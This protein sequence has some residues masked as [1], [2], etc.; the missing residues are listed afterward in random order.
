MNSKLERQLAEL[1][2]ADII[3]SETAQK[4]TAFYHTKDESKPNRLFTIFGVLGALLSGL[5][6]ILIIAHNWDDMPRNI[7]TIFAFIP[8]LIGQIACGYSLIKK[9]SATWIESSATFLILAV[10]ATISLVSQIYNIPGDLSNFLLVWTIITA[11]LIY[12]LRSNLAVIIHLVLATWYACYSGYSFSGN[13]E[14]W[15]YLVLFA[16][17]IPYYILLQKQKP[18]T[19]ITGVLNWLLPLSLVIVL[20]T[21]TNGDTLLFLMYIGLFGLF[22]NLGQLS[23]FKNQKLRRNGFTIIGSLGTIF[24]LMTLTFE[25]FWKD[26]LKETYD[27]ID[28]LITIVLFIA[29]IATLA[30]LHLKK[31]VQGFNL[32]QY[33]FLII[34]LLYLTRGIGPVYGIV[35]T[36]LLV[37]AL[38]LFAVG[39]GIQKNSYGILNYGLLIITALIICRF[40]DTNLDFIFRGI[41]FIGVGA[42]FFFAN[43]LLIKKQR[44]TA[45]TSN[46]QSHE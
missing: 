21:F 45:I 41:L 33:A 32:F 16:W 12:L 15:L 6:I 17:V 8:L 13:H 26:A 36:N 14:P 31:Q 38:G 22:Y 3:N 35:A 19:N 18:E 37:A 40:F 29:G 11:P 9:K 43:Y 30:Y 46:T 23:I 39:I 2:E 10:G 25:W 5:G 7:K 34:G 4:I 24:L 1:L 28:V 44:K 20:G 42:G 27:E